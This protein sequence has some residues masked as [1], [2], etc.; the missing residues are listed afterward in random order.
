MEKAWLALAGVDFQSGA[1][2][3]SFIS[4]VSL[5]QS[6]LGSSHLNQPYAKTTTHGMSDGG[7][8]AL[9]TR[10]QLISREQVMAYW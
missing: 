6:A 9:V 7:L 4:D 10:L 2:P 5:V 8:L 3:P 1:E